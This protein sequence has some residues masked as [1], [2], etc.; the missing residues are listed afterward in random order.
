MDIK[1]KALAVVS[2]AALVGCEGRVAA[3]DM[4]RVIYCEAIVGNDSFTYRARDSVVR[5]GL[6][7]STIT[8]TDEKGWQRTLTMEA[9]GKYK[10]R[11]KL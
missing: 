4:H 9:A 2:L 11:D 1:V 10:C 7:E 5:V 3:K 8:I 6:G